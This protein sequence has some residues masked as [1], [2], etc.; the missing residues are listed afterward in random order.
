MP[1]KNNTSPNRHV[2]LVDIENIAGTGLPSPCQ[3]S[4][5]RLQIENAVCDFGQAQVVVACN[6]NAMKTVAFEF[7]GCLLRQRSGR[8][9]A[10]MAILGELCDLR[11]MSQYDKVTVCSGDGIFAE[12]VGRIGSLG[13]HTTVV[14]RRNSL[15]R[16]LAMAASEVVFVETSDD[17]TAGPLFG[18]AA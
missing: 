11:T 17:E 16:Q 9:G 14:A 2:V 13:I 5:A 1:R 3:V 18:T 6:H 12:T 7:P 4:E 15:A 10:D 8:D